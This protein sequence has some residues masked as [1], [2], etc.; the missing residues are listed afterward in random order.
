M[1]LYWSR[2]AGPLVITC[3]VPKH[4]RQNGALSAVF[5]ELDPIAD[6]ESNWLGWIGMTVV[7]A[8]GDNDGNDGEVL[9]EIDYLTTFVYDLLLY[10]RRTVGRIFGLSVVGCNA[11]LECDPCWRLVGSFV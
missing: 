10:W 11:S 2:T 9:G 8:R 6:A 4:R 3:V 7:G 1:Y 5:V